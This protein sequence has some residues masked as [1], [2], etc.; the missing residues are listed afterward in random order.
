VGLIAAG[1]GLAAWGIVWIA[2]DGNDNCPMGGPACNSVYDTKTA[3]WILTAGGAAAAG[4]GAVLVYVGH[5]AGNANVA[6]DVTPS[7]LFL[8]GRF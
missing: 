8:R 7:A 1:A 2:V 4:V 6:L 5:R 3:G